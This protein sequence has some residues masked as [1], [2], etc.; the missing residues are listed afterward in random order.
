MSTN[1]ERISGVDHSGKRFRHVIRIVSESPQFV[2][3]EELDGAGAP[4]A[5]QDE[6]GRWVHHEHLIDVGCITKRTPLQMNPHYGTW[7]VAK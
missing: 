4:V 5:H 3:G 6:E 7:E 2:Y 1:I